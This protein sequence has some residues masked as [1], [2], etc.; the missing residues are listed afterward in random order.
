M[1]L[2]YVPPLQRPDECTALEENYMNCLVQKSLKDRVLTDRCVKDSI[3]WFHLECPA[4]AAKFDDPI[5]FK[6]KVRNWF[7]LQRAT[8]E[9]VLKRPD[10]QKAI[11][12]EYG[13]A[14]YPEDVKAKSEVVAFADE[15]KQHNPLIHPTTEDE[16]GGVIVETPF[17]EETAVRDRE[18]GRAIPGFEIRDI[19][20]ADS[21][22]F[23]GSL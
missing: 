18:Y 3:L 7:S 6:R 10:E 21:N 13:F 12:K 1:D 14:R 15:F 9:L 2:F 17:D 22:K 11:E 23:S 8:A 5:E 16:M 4:A 19:T 20:A